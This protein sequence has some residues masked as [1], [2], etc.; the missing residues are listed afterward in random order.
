MKNEGRSIIAGRFIKRLKNKIYQHMTS[1]LKN[2]YI[3]KIDEIIDKPD[4]TCN[5]AVQMKAVNVKPGTYIDLDVENNDKNPN[6]KV[7]DHFRILKYAKK[8]QRAELKICLKNL[9]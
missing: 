3:I 7:G 2:V 5:R 1:V 9:L 6:S 8:L 4:K